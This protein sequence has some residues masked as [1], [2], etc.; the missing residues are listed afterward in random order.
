MIKEFQ[1]QNFGCLFGIAPESLAFYIN[2]MQGSINDLLK[3]NILGKVY[4]LS[5]LRCYEKIG[6]KSNLLFFKGCTE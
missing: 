1:L 2:T 5:I 6:V 4:L 3:I